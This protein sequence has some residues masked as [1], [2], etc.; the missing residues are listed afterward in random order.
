MLELKN[1]TK[2]YDDFG[3]DISLSV[4]AGYITGLIGP[5]GAGKSTAFKLALG[6][7]HPDSGEALLLGTNPARLTAAQKENLGVAI[8]DACFSSWLN[9]MDISLILQNLYHNF[10]RS[11]FLH[12]CTR[13]KL[14]IKKKLKDL[15]T[16]MKAKIRVL[17]AMSHDAKLLILD[18]PTTGLD[19]LARTELLDSMRAYMEPGDRSILISSHISTD[20]EGLCD[21]LYLINNGRILLHEDTDVLLDNYG[22]LKV[23]QAQYESLDKAYV[24]ARKKEHY[25]YCCLTSEKNFY[26]ENEKKIT[27]QNSSI[28]DII[29]IIAGGEQL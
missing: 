26:L 15:S 25:G 16:G 10:D 27:V 7:V 2:Q 21:D 18:E 11:A 23:T 3:L 19:V 29:S 1:V 14:P 6:L 9:L 5:N 4:K 20:L 12:Q 13:Y 8:N 28:D 17:I 22:I 24:L